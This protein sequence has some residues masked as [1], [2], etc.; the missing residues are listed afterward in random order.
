VLK[1][2]ELLQNVEVESFINWELLR[3]FQVYL[4]TIYNLGIYDE[5][6]D[7]LKYF[8]TLMVRKNRFKN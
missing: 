3:H 2:A 5:N 8:Q 6:T 7:C 1:H 4:F